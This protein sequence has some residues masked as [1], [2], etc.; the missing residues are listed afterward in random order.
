MGAEEWISIRDWKRSVE[1]RTRFATRAVDSTL[2][3]VMFDLCCRN[4]VNVEGATHKQVVDLIKSGGDVLTLT[5][6][7][8][9]PQEAEKLE[10]FEDLRYERYISS[11][12]LCTIPPSQINRRSDPMNF[13][14]VMHRWTTAKNGLCLLACRIIMFARGN[15][16]DTWYSMFTWQVDICALGVIENSLLSIWLWRRNSLASTF[17]NCL[18]NG[19]SSTTSVSNISIVYNHA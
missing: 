15:T 19:R 7:S 11:A 6:I 8:V 16:N 5:V 10:P 1:G 2:R 13:L 4:N 18:E 12:F 14:L 9:T 3:M 17:R